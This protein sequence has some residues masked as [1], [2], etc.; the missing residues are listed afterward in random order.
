MPAKLTNAT[1]PV[2][3]GILITGEYLGS[4][5]EFIKVIDNFTHRTTVI[6]VLAFSAL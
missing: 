1:G 2:N 3:I 6:M 5:S 4:F